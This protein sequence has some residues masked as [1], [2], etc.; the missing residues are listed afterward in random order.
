MRDG[1]PIY[2][3][4]RWL[5]HMHDEG[6][7]AHRVVRKPTPE[8]NLA[9]AIFGEAIEDI[10]R[11]P[12]M[13]KESRELYEQTRE[14]ILSDDETYSHSFASLCRL[15]RIDVDGARAALLSPKRRPVFAG[16]RPCLMEFPK[17]VVARMHRGRRPSWWAGD[18]VPEVRR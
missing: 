1:A 4:L 7:F 16:L 10:S 3:G 17:P 6:D 14:W 9:A 11:G 15:F 18:K 5:D 12:G 2:S 8:L 13:S